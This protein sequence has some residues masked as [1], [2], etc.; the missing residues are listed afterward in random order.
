MH[1]ERPKEDLQSH[2]VTAAQIVASWSKKD[3]VIKCDQQ[4]GWAEPCEVFCKPSTQN[5]YLSVCTGPNYR[6]TLSFLSVQAY[7][8]GNKRPKS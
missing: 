3:P 6:N 2:D 5:N 4:I 1:D 8:F 7:V